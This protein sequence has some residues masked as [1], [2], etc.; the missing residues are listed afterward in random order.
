[1]NLLKKPPIPKQAAQ[2]NNFV[3][4]NKDQKVPTSFLYGG[5]QKQQEILSD[6]LA[7]MKQDLLYQN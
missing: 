3:Q 2:I 4:S 5:K 1:M 7:T 6:N